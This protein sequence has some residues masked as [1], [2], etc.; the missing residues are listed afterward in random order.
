MSSENDQYSIIVTRGD[1]TV[2][3]IGPIPYRHVAEQMHRYFTGEARVHTAGAAE[4]EVKIVGYDPSIEHLP[5]VPANAMAVYDLLDHPVQGSNAP[6]PDLWTRMHAQHGYETAKKAW[7]EACVIKA[8]DEETEGDTGEGTVTATMPR[9]MAAIVAGIIDSHM[10]EYEVENPWGVI[11]VVRQLDADRGAEMYRLR[12]YRVNGGTVY[13]VV[14]Q[15]EIE[16]EFA[17]SYAAR[18]WVNTHGQSKPEGS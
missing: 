7:N 14:A 9:E 11:E 5:L 17:D 12:R 13:D 8:L 3:F 10:E 2:V 1:G 16:T 15:V 18:A 4:A 6:F